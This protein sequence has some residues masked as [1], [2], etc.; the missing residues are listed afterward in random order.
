MDGAKTKSFIVRLAIAR[1]NLVETGTEFVVPE[2]FPEGW[3]VI[4]KNHGNIGREYDAWAKTSGVGI[5][6]I[7]TPSGKGN[8]QVYEKL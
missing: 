6:K 4:E 5:V 3:P 8:K 1:T 2:L 7:V